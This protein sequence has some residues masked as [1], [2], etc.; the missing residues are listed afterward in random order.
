M[1]KMSVYL[2][3]NT[4]MGIYNF[5]LVFWKLEIIFISFARKKV[6]MEQILDLGGLVE[7]E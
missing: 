1:S 6:A 2:V 5:G 4:N 3:L 7:R